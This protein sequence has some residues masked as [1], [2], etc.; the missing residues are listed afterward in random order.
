MRNIEK[1]WFEPYKEYPKDA[2]EGFM[3]NCLENNL[4]NQWP[5]QY[6]DFKE[7]V[8]GIV[9]GQFS[10][11]FEVPDMLDY[12]PKRQK[13]N[14]QEFTFSDEV[15]VLCVN[16]RKIYYLPIDVKATVKSKY[17]PKR[18]YYLESPYMNKLEN[19]DLEV[20]FKPM[21]QEEYLTRN[22]PTNSVL[23]LTNDYFSIKRAKVSVQLDYTRGN[24]ADIREL[25]S[26][27][28]NPLYSDIRDI[29]FTGIKEQCGLTGFIEEAKKQRDINWT[30]VR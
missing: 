11:V 19:Y 10:L 30:E 9:R 13:W 7:K 28:T 17:A 12:P 3:K 5:S 14:K 27:K 15:P 24:I 8:L 20:D 2:P 29:F 4:E 18:T 16:K 6:D 25:I 23:R 26:E 22:F 21:I 1:A